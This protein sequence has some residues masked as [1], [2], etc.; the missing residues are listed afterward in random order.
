[1]FQII[2][3]HD[4]ETAL[5]RL[6][7]DKSLAKRHK[8]VSKSLRYLMENPRHPSLQTHKFTSL[9]GPRG[10]EIFE[11]YAEQHAPAAYRIFWHYGPS[12]GEITVIAIV[13]HP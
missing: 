1:M 4:A 8:A 12:R 5:R 13:P 2:L 10:E 9:S 7:T 6:A 11:A 3:T